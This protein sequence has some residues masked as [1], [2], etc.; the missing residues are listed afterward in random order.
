MTGHNPN[1]GQATGFSL[2]ELLIVIVILSIL[3]SLTVLYVVASRRAAN[4]A[5]AIQSLRVLSQAEASYSAGVGNRKFAE[6]QDLFDE[7]MID[8]GLARACDPAPTGTSKSGYPALAREPKSGYFF[9]FTLAPV[10]TESDPP[11]YSVLARPFVDTGIARTGD[12]TF[13]I[14]QSGVIRTSNG[15]TV[16]ATLNSQPLN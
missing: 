4:G 8:N 1:G 16:Q 9:I 12:R 13:F 2:I 11:R 6:P 3:S 14:D 5:S 7:D 10:L 15:P